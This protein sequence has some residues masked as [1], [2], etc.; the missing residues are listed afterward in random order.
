MEFL[1]PNTLSKAKNNDVFR[2]LKFFKCVSIAT[3]SMNYSKKMVS[4]VSSAS[5]MDLKWPISA[6]SK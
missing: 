5:K 6:H 2:S 1:V 4:K 3:I